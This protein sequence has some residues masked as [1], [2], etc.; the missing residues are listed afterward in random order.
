MSLYHLKQKMKI[1]KV[2]WLLSSLLLFSCLFIQCSVHAQNLSQQSQQF[3]A[4]M[5]A[6]DN[7]DCCESSAD[8]C[9]TAD[10]VAYT[11]VQ[12]SYSTL[13]VA[14]FSGLSDSIAVR[15]HP[16]KISQRIDV[17][18]AKP[19]THLINCRFTL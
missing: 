5:S 4:S 6:D 1:N 15:L 19:P 7:H 2:N 17:I 14:S 8:C 9:T 16:P 13:L 12:D 3:S 18:Q 10:L 11:P